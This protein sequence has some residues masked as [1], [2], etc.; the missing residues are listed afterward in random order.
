MRGFAFDV[1]DGSLGKWVISLSHPSK[2]TN[3]GLPG[4]GLKFVCWVQYDLFFLYRDLQ[5]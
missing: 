5:S 2:N 1:D 4:K 3:A